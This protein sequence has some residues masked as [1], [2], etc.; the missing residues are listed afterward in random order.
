M[1]SATPPPRNVKSK[2][3]PKPSFNRELLRYSA[4]RR[5]LVMEFV[6]LTEALRELTALLRKVSLLLASHERQNSYQ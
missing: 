1:R 6:A 3:R 4:E 2:H 5:T